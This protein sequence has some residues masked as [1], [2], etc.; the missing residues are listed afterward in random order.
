MQTRAWQEKELQTSLASWTELRHDTILYA[1]QSYTPVPGA[2][3][4]PPQQPKPKGYVEPVPEFY[5]RL[6][7][8]TKMTEKGLID[9]DVLDETEKARLQR[10][11]R[12][13]ERLIDISKAELENKEL[14]ENDYE[15]IR[16]FG[17]RLDSVVAGVDVEGKETTI[18]A[19]VHTDCNTKKVLEEGVGY[20]NLILVAYT[21]PDGRI[22]VGAGPVFSYYEFKQEM[23]DRLTDEKW[24]EMLRSNPPE[25]PGWVR[26][27]EAD[28]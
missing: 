19:D 12:I 3:P 8:L 6:L 14:T 26:G 20:V 18:V 1:K 9:L 10:L 23:K 7:A 2:L 21:V 16:N 24:K 27:I 15:F 5:A 25:R 22:I 17:E 13:L 11:E 28:W 4:Q